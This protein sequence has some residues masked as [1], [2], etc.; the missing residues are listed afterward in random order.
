MYEITVAMIKPQI[1]FNVVQKLLSHRALLYRSAPSSSFN[2]FWSKAMLNKLF[3]IV[4]FLH[5]SEIPP[6]P[7][8]LLG[9]IFLFV[10][11]LNNIEWEGSEKVTD[12]NSWYRLCCCFCSL[13]I[14]ACTKFC[15]ILPCKLSNNTLDVCRF[16]PVSSTHFHRHLPSFAR[17]SQEQ[18]RWW[19]KERLR[20]T[21]ISDWTGNKA[22]SPDSRPFF[23][24]LASICLQSFLLVTSVSSL[25]CC[26]L[27]NIFLLED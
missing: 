2:D 6:L 12:C 27:V 25:S 13:L 3:C 11:S 22:N 24:H 10:S 17:H 9:R 18:S 21:R 16:P 15:W 19:Q 14:T 26:L 7:S 5:L 1:A 8:S 23:Y 4:S 20:V